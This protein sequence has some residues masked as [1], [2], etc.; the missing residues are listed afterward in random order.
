[1]KKLFLSLFLGAPFWALSQT[2][3][4]QSISSGAGASSQ[5]GY[6]VRQTIGQAYQT[7]TS[8]AGESA[9]RPGFQQPYFDAFVVAS[10]LTVRVIPNPALMSFIIECSDTL[11]NV[12]LTVLDESGRTIYK[13]Q[14]Q[15]LS[16]YHMQCANWANGVYLVLVEDDKKNLIST[17]LI[18]HQ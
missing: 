5:N 18:K 3:S 1:M 10:N 15:H 7:N 16:T 2:L 11:K 14:L 12:H 13:E 6:A 4:R 17:R 8:R 9:L